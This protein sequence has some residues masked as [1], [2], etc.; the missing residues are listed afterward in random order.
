MNYHVVEIHHDDVD[1]FVR[2]YNAHQDEI[3]NTNIEFLEDLL[4]DEAPDGSW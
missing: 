2:R 3:D 1:E 4:H